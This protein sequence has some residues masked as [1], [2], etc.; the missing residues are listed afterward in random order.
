M[1]KPVVVFACL[2]VAY[3]HECR[4]CVH[5]AC[6]TIPKHHP[7]TTLSKSKSKSLRK[8]GESRAFKRRAAASTN[9]TRWRNSNIAPRLLFDTLYVGSLFLCIICRVVAVSIFFK[10][11]FMAS[12]SAILRMVSNDR[13]LN[14]VA[15]LCV[16][17]PAI[18]ITHRINYYEEFVP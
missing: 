1:S 5:S 12:A 14:D 15:M 18:L 3:I 16:S 9:P 10:F 2:F 7:K 8:G 6:H 17:L 13:M 11:F 4:Y